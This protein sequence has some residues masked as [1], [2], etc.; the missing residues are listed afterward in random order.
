MSSAE[1]RAPSRGSTYAQTASPYSSS[2]I[3]LRVGTSAPDLHRLARV[4][5]QQPDVDGN[6]RVRVHAFERHFG[7][8]VPGR[9]CR[10]DLVLTIPIADLKMPS[11]GRHG[12]KKSGIGVSKAVRRE[13][14]AK[15]R[16]RRLPT[17]A[18]RSSND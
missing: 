11:L 4:I 6:G 17:T 8:P 10:M 15:R 7:C 16:M 5:A 12:W 1:R 9:V 14:G 18:S 3:A 13:D 2:G